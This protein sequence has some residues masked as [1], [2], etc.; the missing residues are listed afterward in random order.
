MTERFVEDLDGWW[1]AFF[2]SM[3]KRQEETDP[4]R[5]RVQPAPSVGWDGI[6]DFKESAPVPGRFSESRPGYRGVV[7]YHR[8]FVLP[9][10]WAGGE[11]WLEFTARSEAQ[12]FLD[13]RLVAEVSA[14]KAFAVNLGELRCRRV[15]NLGLRVWH[16][17]DSGGIVGSVKLVHRSS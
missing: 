6:D 17:D 9:E 14:E 8:P 13:E 10:S 11:I 3:A 12:V 2:D 4:A 16:S 1:H 15:Y 5:S 7:W